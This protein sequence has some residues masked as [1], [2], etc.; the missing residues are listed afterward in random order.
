MKQTLEYLSAGSVACPKCGFLAAWL[1]DHGACIELYGMCL[2]C[3]MAQ[4]PDPFTSPAMEAEAD[5]KIAAV[6]ELRE[7]RERRTGRR[8]FP[9]LLHTE[10]ACKYCG[11]RGWILGYPPGSSPLANG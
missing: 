8:V 2:A 1:G 10:P 9:C 4:Y 5:V 7:D 6:V 11:G 3:L